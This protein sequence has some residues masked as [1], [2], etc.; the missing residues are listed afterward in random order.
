MKKEKP[1]TGHRRK[2]RKLDPNDYIA[3]PKKPKPKKTKK[4][5]S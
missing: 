4:S 5:K 2:L 1:I 3:T